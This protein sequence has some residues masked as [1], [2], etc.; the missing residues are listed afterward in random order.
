MRALVFTLSVGLLLAGCTPV[1]SE[2]RPDAQGHYVLVSKT[3]QQGASA[4]DDTFVQ[5]VDQRIA[6]EQS[7]GMPM[8]GYKK[9]GDF[10][11]TWYGN[12]RRYQT[13]AWQPSAFKTSEDLVAYIKQKRREHGLP[14]YDPS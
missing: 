6:R 10:W 3:R 8:S 9:A 5:L 4:G 11:H 1:V 14:S 7:T 13:P 2:Y 12:I